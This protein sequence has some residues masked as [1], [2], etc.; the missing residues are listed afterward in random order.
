MSHNRSLSI[1]TLAALALAG[2]C[3]QAAPP[4]MPPAKP[5]E[6][7]VCLPVFQEIADYEDFTGQTE[8]VKTIDLRARVTGYLTE[9][10]FQ[11]GA[12][13]EKGDLLFEIDPPYYKAEADRAAGVVAQCEARLDRLKLDYARAE[14]LR[15]TNVITKE[16]FDLVSGDLAEGEANLQSAKASLKI[17]N[18]NLGYCEIRAPIAGRMSRPYID[19]GNLVKADDTI[20]TRIVAQDPMWVYFDLDERTMLRL[21]RLEQKGTMSQPMDA[22]LPVLMGLADEK[23]YQHRG[24]IDFEENRLDPS[25]GT[26][27]VRGV[28]ENHDRLLKPGLF[29]RVRVPIGEPYHALLV[30]EPAVGTDQGQKFLYVLDDENKVAYRRVQVGKLHDGLRVIA[31][32]LKPNER[33]VVVG[34]Q[35]VRPDIKVDAQLIPAIQTASTTAAGNPP[36]LPTSKNTEAR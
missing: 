32:G 25:T 11:H 28:F 34:L 19:P 5:P 22:Q 33:V 27:R 4:Q 30:P 16:Q 18:V 35:R 17:A 10:N 15:P 29:V 6:V 7:E 8:S 3:Q 2:G 36:G 20:L 24:S 21:R 13:V 31:E 23:D 9:V 1:V 12:E 14:K 26:L